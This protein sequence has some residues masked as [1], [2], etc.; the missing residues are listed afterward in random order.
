MS[1]DIQGVIAGVSPEINKVRSLVERASMVDSVV[2]LLGESGTGKDVAANAIHHLS[3]RA[4]EPFV[5][6]NCGAI[7]ADLMASELFGH[8]RG[9][10]T[11]AND[12]RK[13]CFERAG[14]GTLFLDEIAEMTQEMQ[15]KLLRVLQERTLQRLGS[16][17]ENIEVKARI[18]AATNQKLDQRVAEG[19]FRSDLY[20]RLNVLPIKIPPLRSRHDD[21]DV[22]ID[23]AFERFSTRG[24]TAPRLSEKA[25]TLLHQHPWPGNIRQ[26]FNILERLCVF[27]PG[28]DVGAGELPEDILREVWENIKG[29]NIDKDLSLRPTFKAIAPGLGE[30]FNLNQYLRDIEASIVDMALDQAQ[31]GV[32]NAAKLL[33]ISRTTLAEKLK[34]HHRR[35]TGRHATESHPVSTGAESTGRRRTTDQEEESP[36][37][38]A[39][40]GE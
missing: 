40:A 16:N 15:V 13:G 35:A 12:K 20:Y 19:A 22:L 31:G 39:V 25:R 9:A 7:P 29:N 26:L 14:A 33:G 6:V 17:G 8:E 38:R 11:G 28:E 36:R 21:I 30:G 34:R 10:F 4:E 1:Q 27:Y 2:L 32:S 37:I 24:L 23:T 5:A 3:S 18:I